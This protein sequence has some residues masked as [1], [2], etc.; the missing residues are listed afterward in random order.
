MIIG[1]ALGHFLNKKVSF[2]GQVSYFLAVYGGWSV[3]NDATGEKVST[4]T[5]GECLHRCLGLVS[6]RCTKTQSSMPL[7]SPVALHNST[8]ELKSLWMAMLHPYVGHLSREDGEKEVA[9][10]AMTRQVISLP[11][12]ETYETQMSLQVL[13]VF[14]PCRG[15]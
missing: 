10:A 15:H 9:C 3:E 14:L 5:F 11:N 7:T 12:Y 8:C 1:D 2:C 6:T 4:L 13:R